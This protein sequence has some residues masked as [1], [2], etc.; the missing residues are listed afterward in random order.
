MAILG[1]LID[2]QTVSR[3]GDGLTGVTL[4]TLSHSIPATNPD[5]VIPV[6]RSVQAVGGNGAN[7]LPVLLGHGANASLLTVGFA[8]PSAVSCATILYDVVAF[9]FHSIIR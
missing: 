6:L 4:T 7:A 5:T 2:K 1:T 3:A 8:M 9:S